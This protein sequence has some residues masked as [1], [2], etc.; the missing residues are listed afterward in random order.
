MAKGELKDRMNSQQFRDY[1]QKK[2]NAEHS[3][4]KAIPT[5]TADGQSFRSILE[6]NF[7]KRMWVLQQAGEVILIE[8]EV[9]YELIVNGLFIAA[10]L[11]DFRI[12]NADGTMRYIDCKSTATKTPLYL[13]KKQLMKALYDIEIEEVFN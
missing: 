2:N 12:T 5:S 9:R 1:L 13:M 10:Y 7:Y 8:R 4:F 3:K 6:A 11:M